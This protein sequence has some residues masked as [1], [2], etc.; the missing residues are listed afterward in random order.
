MKRTLLAIALCA[1]CAGYA[2]AQ[3]EIKRFLGFSSVENGGIILVLA[4]ILAARTAGA[5]ADGKTL[6]G[7]AL[8]IAERCFEI[9][10]QYALE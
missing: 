9:F 10:V 4:R 3:D 2:V 6:G 7:L 1:A 5:G 8:E